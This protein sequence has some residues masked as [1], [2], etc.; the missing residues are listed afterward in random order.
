MELLEDLVVAGD[1]FVLEE[2][3]LFGNVGLVLEVVELFLQVL[4][5]GEGLAGLLLG[6]LE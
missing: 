1:E 5:V 2:E 3:F 4:L 6:R